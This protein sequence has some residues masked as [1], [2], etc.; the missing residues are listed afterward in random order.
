MTT[1]IIEQEIEI[2]KVEKLCKSMIELFHKAVGLIL[3]IRGTRIRIKNKNSQYNPIDIQ[4][5]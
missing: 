4:T 3:T 1:A 2:I 5:D